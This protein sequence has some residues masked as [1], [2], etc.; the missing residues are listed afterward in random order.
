M[1]PDEMSI[2]SVEYALHELKRDGETLQ[3][4]KMLL[5]ALEQSLD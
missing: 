2:S 4:A 3:R 5:Y 1:Q